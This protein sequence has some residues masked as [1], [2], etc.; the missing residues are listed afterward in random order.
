M[1]ELAFDLRQTVRALRKSPAFTF[2]VIAI[3][4]LGLGANVL[5]LS[6]Y[7]NVVLRPLGYA[8][9]ASPV[10]TIQC[11]GRSGPGYAGPR[12]R[13]ARPAGWKHACPALCLRSC[14]QCAH[15][16]VEY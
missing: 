8:E 14:N 13:P 10:P 2:G 6:V 7:D 12:T 15:L 4:A 5:I 1:G 16:A 3:L 9:P 11:S